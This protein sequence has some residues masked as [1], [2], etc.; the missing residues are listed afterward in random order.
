MAIRTFTEQDS[1]VENP[2]DYWTRTKNNKLEE[3]ALKYLIV[4][5]TS[6]A[7]ERIFSKAGEIISKKRSNIKS[8]NVNILIFLNK[9]NFLFEM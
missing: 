1:H 3:L 8:K 6:V 2:I 7:S 4:P 9:N 5:A